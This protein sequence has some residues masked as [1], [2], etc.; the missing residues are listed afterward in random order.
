MCYA[1]VEHIANIRVLQKVVRY[2]KFCQR[3]VE[4]VREKAKL[5]R[6]VI[7]VMVRESM[8]Q[9]ADIAMELGGA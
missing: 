5:V 2:F 8:T 6:H 9:N 7:N 1:I 3:N 4:N